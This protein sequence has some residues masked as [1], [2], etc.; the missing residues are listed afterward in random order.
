MRSPWI[1][2]FL[3]PTVTHAWLSGLDRVQKDFAALTR[4]VT[5]RHI[6]LPP[7][8]Q[9][10]ALA[11]KQKIRQQCCEVRPETGNYPYIVDVFAKVAAK[12]SRDD[13]TN[14]RGGLLGELVPQGYC[15]DPVLDRACFEVPIGEIQG[16]IQS[17]CGWHLVLIEER[18]NCPKLDGPNTKL[19]PCA[20][21]GL[22]TVVPSAQEG[23]VDMTTLLKDQALFWLGACLAG[24]VVAEVA[25]SL[26]N[27]LTGAV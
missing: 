25:A 24:G 13:T 3:V 22:G 14:Q 9:E 12:Y 16:P 19:V 10:V 27:S 5:A 8:G 6:L 20:R 18:T 15:R 7:N 23:Q 21:H 17:N 2:L 26:G 1:L 11:L 4:R